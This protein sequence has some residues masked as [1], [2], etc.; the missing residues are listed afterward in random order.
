MATDSA[1]ER[2]IS[3]ISL[4]AERHFLEA[5]LA[6]LRVAGGR[7]GLAAPDVAGLAEAVEEV[8][9]NVLEQ[10]FGPGKPASFDV[11][12]L[13]RPGH[14]VIAIE[15][16]GLPFD[17]A[18][19]EAGKGSGLAIPS[20][21]RFADAVRFVNLGTRG[22]RVEIVK[23]LPFEHIDALIAG[24]KAAPVAPASTETSAEAVSLR[25]MTPEDA[26]AVARCTYAVYGYTLPDDYLYVPDRL[27]EMLEGGLLE[28]CVGTTPDGEVVCYLTCEV[29]HP[30]APVGYLEEGLVHPRFRHHGLLEQM[31]RFT[32]RR[33]TER[34][35]LGLYAEAVTVHPYS[36]KSNLALGFSEM[37]A[38]LAD[39][40]PVVFEQMDDATSKKRTATILEFLKTNEGPRRTVYAPPHHRAMIERL[41]AHGGFRR[42]MKHAATGS[43]PPSGAQVKVDAFPAWS[44]ASI[45]VTA[46]GADLPDLVRARLRELCLR[47]IDWICLDLPLAHPGAG[48]LCARLEALG[49]FFA[50]IIPDIADDDILRLQYLNEVE[51]EVDSAQL[52]S[53]FGKELFAYVV[54]AMNEAPDAPSR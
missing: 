46:Y 19:L 5:V 35:M 49:F 3:R 7:L 51:A 18:S 15:D 23:R 25:L 45:R 31:L 17:F 32:Q 29:E 2:Q 8:C 43:T 16:Q 50:G 21:T 12:L 14:L 52:A 48:E 20:L 24:G 41:Y 4:A 33:A 40:A 11:V 42:D 6:F 38:Q 27:R 47:R 44:E 22:N 9:L 26:I 34:G 1:N 39:E 37:G 54:G 10:G 13:R 28:V 30:G 36:Q 53:D